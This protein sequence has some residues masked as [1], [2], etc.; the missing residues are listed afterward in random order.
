MAVYKPSLYWGSTVLIVDSERDSPYH[1]FEE[2]GG[3]YNPYLGMKKYIPNHQRSLVERVH[4]WGEISINIGP[5][6]TKLHHPT[7]TFWSKWPVYPCHHLSISL[8]IHRPT[9]SS[10]SPMRGLSLLPTKPSMP[11]WSWRL[12]TSQF[13]KTPTWSLLLS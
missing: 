9:F 1:L 13:W 4:F 11:Y 10:S 8:L 12:S 2:P 3:V 5:I 6:R 7:P